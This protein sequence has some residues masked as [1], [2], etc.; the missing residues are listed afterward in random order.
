MRRSPRNRYGRRWLRRRCRAAPTANAGSA[1]RVAHEVAQQLYFAS[2]A[3]DEKPGVARE[4][5]ER[6]DA[7]IFARHALP[8][9]RTLGSVQHPQVTHPV[10]ETLVHLSPTDPRE[11]LLANAGAIPDRGPYLAES[12]AAAVVVPYLTRLLAEH[13]DLVLGDRECTNAFRHLLQGFAGA[14]HPD[15]LALA[16]TFSDVFR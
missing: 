1:A 9:L 10:V 2:G 14:G 11:A 6:G 13:R 16:Y 12:I 4:P 8:L 5:V 3:F 15:A 7:A